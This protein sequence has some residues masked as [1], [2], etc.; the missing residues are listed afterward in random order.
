MKPRVAKSLQFSATE[1]VFIY[2]TADDIDRSDLFYSDEDIDLMG[3]E[4]LRDAKAINKK[5]ET[6][7]VSGS[8]KELILRGM[9]L[10]GVENLLSKE[11]A[12]K[13]SRYKERQ[14]YSVL[15]EQQRQRELGRCDP[16]R[17]AQI[18]KSLS[19]WAVERA[20]KIAYH[21]SRY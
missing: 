21:Q 1:E 10:T 7:S 2:D 17:L 6:I 4:R 14:I 8:Q 13:S 3:N 11:I 18:S 20:E 12:E 15:H 16:L 19:V 5:Y 9:N